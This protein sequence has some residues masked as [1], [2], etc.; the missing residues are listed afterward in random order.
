VLHVSR[1]AVATL[2][3]LGLASSA[4]TLG[5]G[6]APGPMA[7]VVLALVVGPLA[8]WCTRRRLSAVRLLA[9]LGG[10]QVLVHAALTAM[11]PGAGTGSALH[12]HG[13]LP[14]GLGGSDGPLHAH[15]GIGPG[16]L[17]AHVVATVVTALVLARAEDVLWRVVLLLLPRRT[18]P[19]RVPAG[20]RTAP[21]P[22]VVAVTGRVPRP[23][24]GRAPPVVL[25]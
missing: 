5:G 9:L 21:S 14:P 3:V 11:A 17:L 2:L 12:V 16:M 4:H 19:A 20:F 1:A 7:G 23:L 10:A 22:V 8:W 24:G 15:H 18:R 25:A 6:D 13:G